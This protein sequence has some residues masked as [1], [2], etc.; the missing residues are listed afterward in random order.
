MAP[1]LIL[2][3]EEVPMGWAGSVRIGRA[4]LALA[5][6]MLGLFGGKEDLPQT[7][8]ALRYYVENDCEHELVS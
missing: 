7:F 3:I 4:A 5:Y 2:I 6:A 8:A 1:G